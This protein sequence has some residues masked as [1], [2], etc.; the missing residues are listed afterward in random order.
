MAGSRSDRKSIPCAFCNGK[1]LDPFGVPSPVSKCQVCWGKGEVRIKAPT[2][3]CAFCGGSG[4]HPHTR[5]CCTVCCGKGRV[6]L[7]V[8]NVVCDACSGT[9]RGMDYLPCLNCGGAGAVK[10]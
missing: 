3:G 4:V 9:G 5:L 8:P 1:G 6:H 2:H 10:E 7:K